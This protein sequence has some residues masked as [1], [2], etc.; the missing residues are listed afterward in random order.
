[1]GEAGFIA[2]AAERALVL[3]PAQRAVVDLPGEASAAVLGAPGTGKTTTLVELVADRVCARGW[4]PG[5]VLVLAPTRASATRLRDRLARRVALPTTGPLARTPASFAFQLV[6]AAAAGSDARPTL[7]S[8]GEQDAIFRELLEGHLAEGRG[9]AWPPE[10]GPEVRS[11]RAFRTELREL[12]MRCTEHGVSPAALADLGRRSHR[13]EWVAASEFFAEYLAVLAASGTAALDPSELLDAAAA[14]LVRGDADEVVRGVRLVAVD[15]LQEATESVL[16]MLRALARRGVAIVAFGDPDVAANGFRGGDPAALGRL[17]VELRVP[18]LR[19]IVLERAHRHGPQ[20]RALTS[21][22]VARIGTASAGAQRAA[23]AAGPAH[24]H[25]VTLVEATTPA[26][27]YAALARLLREE[28]LERGVPWERMAIVVRSGARVA[29]VARAFAIAE[30]PTR[31]TGG[32]RPLRE[33]RAA[34]TL[35]DIVDVALRSAEDPATALDEHRAA[36]LL[37]SPYGG[38]DRLGLRTLRLALR[39]EELAGGG[40]RPAGVLVAEALLDPA[41]LATIDHRVGRAALRIAGSIAA[42]RARAGEGASIE[43]LLWVVWERSGLADRWAADAST[44]GI[45]ADEANRDLD[46]VLALFSAARRFVERAPDARPRSFVDSV[47]SAEVAEDLL[48]P[49]ARQQSVLVTTPAGTVGMEFDVVA[50]AD[51][52]EGVWPNMRLR[53]SL[54]G[55]QRLVELV[56]GLPEGAVDERRVVRDDELRMFALAV[57]RASRRVLVAAV[58]NEDEAPSVLL[59][60]VPPGAT[61]VDAAAARPLSLGAAVGA[62]RRELTTPGSPLAR[63]RAAA[64]S[65]ARLAAEGV[66][67]AD[68]ADWHGLLPLSTDAPLFDLDDPAVRVPV[69][70]SGI[71]RLEEA[72]LHW[73]LDRVGGASRSPALTLGT[74]LHWALETAEGPDAEAIWR[75]VDERWSELV[76]ESPWIAERE[77][78][79]ARRM[80]DGIAAYLARCEA[81]GAR[82]VAAEHAFELEVDRA[83]VHGTIDRVERLPDGRVVIVDLKTGNPVKAEANPQLEA[84]QAAYAAGLVEGLEEGHR[85]GGARLLFVK[86]TTKAPYRIAEQAPFGPEE[87]A[88]FRERVTRAARLIAAAE[89]EGRLELDE[90]RPGTESLRWHVVPAVTSD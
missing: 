59:S 72:P 62:L 10:L 64:S 26:R 84:Y 4:A 14:A 17:G 8:G 71:E 57:S 40:V 87:L 44:A 69:S 70:P 13:P 56:T 43:D 12:F 11:V 53:G 37:L 67:G 6:H 58:A 48:A 15:D 81:E 16:R 83:V 82:A 42:V 90:H 76:F 41:R 20:L 30:V 21:A 34:R 19:T 60:L 29:E 52:Q 75:R 55:A 73:F 45:A 24:P 9:P 36:E 79:L 35:L 18:G 7:L 65:L 23:V 25:S 68:P 49:R 89:F 50:I 54:L 27:Q 31:T 46:A 47:L 63:R 80:T 2:A 3:D 85:A 33:E 38:L 86:P 1:M 78:R 32:G 51:V 74:I 61:R 39:A 22:V 88:A 77:R 5:E 66:P 28:R